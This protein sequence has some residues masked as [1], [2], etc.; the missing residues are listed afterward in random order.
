MTAPTCTEEGYT[1]YICACGDS[2][3]AD[4]TAAL[5]HSYTT[6]EEDGALVHTCACGHS[7]TEKLD[8]TYGQASA[9]TD[10]DRFVITV[11]SGSKYYALSHENN[12]LSA[13]QVKVSDGEITTEITEDLL[14]TYEDGKLSYESDGD[15]YYLNTASSGWWWNT[16]TTLGVS[17]GSSAS[18]SFSGTKLKVGS[19][20]LR[21]SSGKLSLSS[22]AGSAYIFV[23]E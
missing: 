19:S 6:T 17:T 20:Y 8:F 11:K 18:I 9:L 21:Y 1:T 13:V 3:V 7:Y 15:T 10:G 22:R 12:S 16:S 2:Y 5:G 23:E 14:W 4:K